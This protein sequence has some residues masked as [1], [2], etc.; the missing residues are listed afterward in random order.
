M[1]EEKKRVLALA[2]HVLASMVEYAIVMAVQYL[3]IMGDDSVSDQVKHGCLSVLAQLDAIQASVIFHD[4]RK[5]KRKVKSLARKRLMDMDRSAMP[6]FTSHENYQRMFKMDARTFEWF[7]EQVGPFVEKMNTNYKKS[8]PVT[9]RVA[10]AL[11]RLATGANYLTA[12]EKFSVGES[13]VFYCTTEL[14]E[15]LCTRFRH[16]VA[17][18]QG[19]GL[20][21]AVSRFEA[22]S[23]LPNCAGAISCM[24]LRIKRPAGPHSAEYLNEDR[25]HTI[26]TQAV[27]DS[28]TRVLSFASGFAGAVRDVDALRLSTFPQKVQYG[29][30]SGISSVEL[31]D[32]TVPAYIVGG[33]SYQ[34]KPWL[35]VPYTGESLTDVQLNFNNCLTETWGV[36]DT[37]FAALKKWEILNGVMQVDVPTAVYMIGA[38]CIIHNMLLDK[39]DTY[40]DGNQEEDFVLETSLQ[41]QTASNSGEDDSAVELEHAEEI[42]NALASHMMSV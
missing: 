16:K 4:N 28:N 29:R 25:V 11:F 14:C 37:T 9:K 31:D 21:K 19:Q 36:A 32:A 38:V 3:E 40:I 35:M 13:T 12:A 34:L 7:C 39:V 42:R 33:P 26:V 1:D 15:I 5:R 18:P 30:F 22:I 2:V 27:V 41:D 10:V 24:H 6:R 20:K 23:G 17:Y 8:I